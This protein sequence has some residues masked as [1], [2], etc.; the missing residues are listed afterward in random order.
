MIQMN[1]R[2]T[3]TL[4]RSVISS[5]LIDTFYKL[6][7][8]YIVDGLKKFKEKPADIKDQTMRRF[9]L[10]ILSNNNI[11]RK[12]IMESFDD[13]IG[14]MWEKDNAAKMVM[15]KDVLVKNTNTIIDTESLKIR[16]FVLQEQ[17][18]YIET[19]KAKFEEA[20]DEAKQDLKEKQ[21]KL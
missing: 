1:E 5:D 10:F 21:P 15:K 9:C 2:L 14:D 11:A 7:A 17:H 4:R 16:D 12:H 19:M 18:K 20:T 3:V 6:F 13:L 8:E